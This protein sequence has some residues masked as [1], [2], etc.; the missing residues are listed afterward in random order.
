MKERWRET[1]EWLETD[2][3]GG[4]A[5]GMADGHAARRYHG[6]LLV[7]QRPPTE[8][9]M[10]VNGVEA[11]LHVPGG[12]RWPL[13]SPCYGD[14]VVYPDGR[15]YLELFTSDPWPRWVYTFPDGTKVEQELLIPRGSPAVVIT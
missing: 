7:A 10:L 4:F 3:L 8:R 1:G 13:S 9:V 14:G 12:G 11:Y 15:R 5:S 2:G 6:L